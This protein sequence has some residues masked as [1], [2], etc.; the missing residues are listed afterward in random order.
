MEKS[1]VG[2]RGAVWVV[3]QAS[4]AL[5]CGSRFAAGYTALMR[6][7]SPP[8]THQ[9]LPPEDS[10]VVLA[11]EGAEEGHLDVLQ[12]AWLPVGQVG[13]LGSREDGAK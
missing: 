3:S 8:A 5:M 12:C 7:P 1:K 9:C 11:K 2:V 13:V 4:Q 6:P 10:A